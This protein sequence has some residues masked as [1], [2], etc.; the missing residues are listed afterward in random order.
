MYV[1]VDIK[2][3]RYKTQVKWLLYLLKAL[4]Y[5]LLSNYKHMCWFC[6]KDK[7]VGDNK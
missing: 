7:K 2:L 4:W 3:A 6:K 1:N 5:N